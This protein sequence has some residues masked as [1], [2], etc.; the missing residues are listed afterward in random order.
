MVIESPFFLNNAI[1][2]FLILS[3]FGPFELFIAASPSFFYKPT[4]LLSIAVL[5]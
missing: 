2:S 1:I 4:L 3:S 5:N